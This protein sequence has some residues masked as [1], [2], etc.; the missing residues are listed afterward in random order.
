MGDCMS[1]PEKPMDFIKDYSFADRK[2]VYT[3]GSELVS[4]FRVEQ[5]VEHYMT[6]WIP[7]TERRPED[8]QEVL[9]T[10]GRNIYM[11]EYDEGG[12]EFD[13]EDATHWMPLP[14]LPKEDD[15]YD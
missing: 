8:E 4:V 11:I 3:N 2:E 10:D 6:R 9:C 14:E 15:Y 13:L 7:V 1:Y 5:M 12:F